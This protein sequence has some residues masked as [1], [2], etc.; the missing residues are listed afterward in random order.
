M[1][2]LEKPGLYALMMLLGFWVMFFSIWGVIFNK[3]WMYSIIAA[4]VILLF[5]VFLLTYMRS[6]LPVVTKEDAFEEFEK[7]LKGG[8]FHFKCPTCNGIFA[9]KRSQGNG[10][11]S[12]KMTCPN[13]GELG[14]MPKEA[15]CIEEEIPEKKSSGVN[16]RCKIC[17]KGVTIWAEG[18][19]IHPDIC[20][21]SCP[22]CGEQEPMQ[23][24]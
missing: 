15:A 17:G 3:D 23:Q 8:L 24:I 6:K 5:L 4:Y 16:F 21:Y 13:C 12:V 19:E 7:A 9:I 11:K 18:S 14:I 1:R 10:K 2:F 22:F 20:L